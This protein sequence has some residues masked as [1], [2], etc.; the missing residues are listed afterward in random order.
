LIGALWNALALTGGDLRR[1]R[2]LSQPTTA[3][4]DPGRVRGHA[5]MV[6]VTGMDAGNEPGFRKAMG[7]LG[8]LGCHLLGREELGYDPPHPRV[9]GVA[10]E[11]RVHLSGGFKAAIPY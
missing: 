6:R 8:H 9:T 10:E 5:L 4:G 2:Y 11:F 3:L 7:G 1:V